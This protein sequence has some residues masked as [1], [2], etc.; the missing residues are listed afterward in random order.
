MSAITIA[1][2][3][4]VTGQMLDASLRQH[5]TSVDRAEKVQ[6]AYEEQIA[7]LQC[8]VQ[9]QAKQLEQSNAKISL[10]EENHAVLEA[11][12][13][14]QEQASKALDSAQKQ[15]ITSLQNQLSSCS[16]QVSSLQS[17]LNASSPVTTL[18]QH[19]QWLQSL[20]AGR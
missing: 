13:R 5:Q 1:S 12:K 6:K 11:A 16:S 18:E 9:D 10:L 14:A 20:L 4:Q 7:I 17:R 19:K 8:T 2:V 15:Q 3:A